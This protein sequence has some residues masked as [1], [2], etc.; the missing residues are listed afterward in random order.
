MTPLEPS[1]RNWIK[2]GAFRY[3]LAV[4]LMASLMASCRA[5]GSTAMAIEP[6]PSKKGD[7]ISGRDIAKSG[8]CVL[9][10]RPDPEEPN[11]STGRLC[12]LPGI[13]AEQS[14][15]SPMRLPPLN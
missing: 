7:K 14:T 10:V 4:L 11:T 13:G 6:S 9:K 2:R 8:S 3:R 15:P 5:S 1:Q 12:E